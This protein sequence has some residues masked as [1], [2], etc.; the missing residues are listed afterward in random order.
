VLHLS[1][2]IFFLIFGVIL[3]E[4]LSAPEGEGALG[5][6]QALEDVSGLERDPLVSEVGRHG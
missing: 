6:R 3:Q 1:L 2:G 5:I 4:A